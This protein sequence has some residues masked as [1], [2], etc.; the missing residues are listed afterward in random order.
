MK[1]NFQSAGQDFGDYFVNRKFFA[2]TVLWGAGRGDYTLPGGLDSLSPVICYSGDWQNITP[3]GYGSMI[4]LKTDGSWWAWGYNGYGELGTNDRTVRSSPVQIASAFSWKQVVGDRLGG[5]SAAIRSDG[6]LWTVGYNNSGQLGDGTVTKRS[7]PVQVSGG[8]T[9][10]R[11][12]DTTGGT[13]FGVKE[14]GT[15]WSWGTNSYGKLGIGTSVTTKVSTPN[16]VVGSNW[17]YIVTGNR[18]VLGIKPDGSLW[19]W[20]AGEAWAGGVGGNAPVRFT[21]NDWKDVSM[22]EYMVIMLKA[23]TTMWIPGAT[24]NTVVPVTNGGTGWKKINAG[25]GTFYAIKTD[26]TLW[27][28]GGGDSYTGPVVRGKNL[29]GGGTGATQ[30]TQVLTH[31]K[32]KWATGGWDGLGVALAYGQN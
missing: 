24:A 30:P 27:T 21:D 4:G 12:V 13:T 17:K 1:T 25:H 9:T 26:D 32:F 28:W 5:T 22:C 11:Y 23:N 3:Y 19:S 31:S 8:G 16:Q 6:T 2:N 20:G 15:A 10:W 29:D 14:D 7:S 18:D